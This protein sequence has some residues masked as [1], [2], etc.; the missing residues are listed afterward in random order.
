MGGPVRASIQDVIRVQSDDE[1]P[2]LLKNRPKVK[3]KEEKIE[4]P[5]EVL[6]YNYETKKEESQSKCIFNQEIA[7]TPDMLTVNQSVGAGK[8]SFQK[9]FSEGEFLASGVLDLPKG[10]MKPNKN[11]HKSAMVRL[12]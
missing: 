3:V 6:V 5:E 1:Q 10:A 2:I 8:Y 11:S 7:V 12:Y 4:V 9:V